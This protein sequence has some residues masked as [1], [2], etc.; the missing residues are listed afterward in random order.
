ML[1]AITSVV[2]FLSMA[3][4]LWLA[5]YLLTRS[6]ASRITHRGVAV[7]VALSAYFFGTY[8]HLYDQIPGMPAIQA[9]LLTV[10][11]TVWNDLTY[12]LLPGWYQ[13]THR[14]RV[15][16]IYAL[17]S[18]NVVLLLWA[19]VDLIG[20]Q[21]DSLWIGRM[22]VQPVDIF[23]RLFQ[24]LT[25]TSILYHCRV[26]A[27]VGVGL[28]NGP[29]LASSLL[30]AGAVIYGALSLVLSLR[31]P[32]FLFDALI[33]GGACLLGFS[34][35]RYQVLIERR[36]TLQNFAISTLIVFVVSDIYLFAAWQMGLSPVALIAVAALVL[37]SH[38]IYSLLREFLDRSRSKE[39]ALARQQ[40]RMVDMRVN[41]SVSLQERLQNGLKLFCQTF[42]SIGA[43]IAIRQDSQYLVLA[44]H[45][46]IPIGTA[47][48]LPEN[49]GDHLFKPSPELAGDVAWLVPAF[50]RG[51][52]VA[53]LGTGPLK[54]GLPYTQD[55]LDLLVDAADRIG[56]ILYLHSHKPVHK[57]SAKRIAFDVQ[58]H[59][60]NLEV[61]QG[62]IITTLIANPDP[63]FIKIIEEGLR[64]LTD[65]ISLGQSSL[66]ERLGVSG[67]THLEKG[68]AVQ[69][70]L[71]EA[72]EAL[73]PGKDCPR[74]PIPREWHS[75]VV[76]HD[77]YW[78]RIPNH[79]I[80][81]KLYVSEGTF[82]RTRRA[83][84]RSV[85]RVLLEK[86]NS[87]AE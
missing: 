74:E 23:S 46:S 44:S 51:D 57:E 9:G 20:S 30:A 33:L 84:V 77:A 14:W 12:K 68:K 26:A 7:L 64:S 29:L 35:A 40:P 72:I 25:G 60:A 5:L 8:L 43:F 6:S 52:L 83:A 71:I 16:L 3:V 63:Q 62:E 66:P 34:V 19:Q 42:E 67:E 73:R 85:A 24:V 55:D 49:R 15:L 69:Q 38:S 17:G 79:D 32:G 21:V 65:F 48:P 80:M 86:Q 81:S 10:A 4:S 54:S 58:F 13:R 53:V 39:E 27:K 87:S 70:R 2:D 1:F 18:L 37:L 47:L 56:I 22:G 31:M 11:V 41:E 28:L 36:T 59:E 50:Q 61:G 76:L 78:E 82:H 75:Y 45:Q